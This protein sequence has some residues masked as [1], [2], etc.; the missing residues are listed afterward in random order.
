MPV[1]ELFGS[2][3]HPRLIAEWVRDHL[4]A[5][6]EDYLAEVERQ[7][8]RLA[9]RDLPVIRSWE[10]APDVER[11]P[12]DQLPAAVIVVP[13][14]DGE[15]RMD[16]EGNYRVDWVVDI[17]L[18]VSARDEES[19]EELV[20][21]YAAAF[22]AAIAQ[23]KSMGGRFAET[24]PTGIDLDVIGDDRTIGIARLR[25]IASVENVVNAYLGP[26]QPSENPYDDPD[27][28]PTVQDTELELTPTP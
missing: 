13:R 19:T 17:G 16:G 2:I 4:Q 22:F 26:P 8:D 11:W 5:F 20:G 18:I 14:T 21:L 3:V 6:Q 25:F 9:P 15:P 23:S 12:E 28:G 1:S 27:D 10:M 24:R 7:T